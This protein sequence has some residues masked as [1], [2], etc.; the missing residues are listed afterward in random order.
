M[1]K[2]TLRT[3]INNTENNDARFKLQNSVIIQHMT[4][5]C[6][7]HFINEQISIDEWGI[8]EIPYWD[9]N[10]LVLCFINK[11]SHEF[12]SIDCFVKTQKIIPILLE[13]CIPIE[14]KNIKEAIVHLD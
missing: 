5:L 8:F 10:K 13:H 4:Y 6:I 1:K 7:K 12:V 11:K 9:K 3:L 14:K 2:K